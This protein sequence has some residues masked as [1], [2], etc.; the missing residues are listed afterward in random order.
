[1]KI[2]RNNSLNRKI[3]LTIVAFVSICIVVAALMLTNN[4]KES[5]IK[6]T[7]RDEQARLEQVTQA[8]DKTNE[9]C[10]LASEII[11]QSVKINQYMELLCNGK[12]MEIMEKLDF[13]QKELISIENMTNSN[14]Y[15]YQVRIYVNSEKASEKAP[16]IYR[17]Q[18]MNNM[19]WAK[20]YHDGEWKLDY[21]DT[22]FPEYIATGPKHLAGLISVVTQAGGQEMYTIECITYMTNLFPDLYEDSDTSWSAFFGDDG[23]LYYK[24]SNSNTWNQAIE[25][26]QEKTGSD[27]NVI[28]TEIDGKHVILAYQ[29]VPLLGGTYVHLVSME[30]AF[31]EFYR[32]LIPYGIILIL[33]L[34]AFVIFS[35][36]AVRVIIQ[37]FYR[38]YDVM[39]RIQ[40]G[41]LDLTL[42]EEGNDETTKLS[43]E[44]NRM[45]A[46]IQE[47]NQDNLDR[48]LLAKNAQIKSL[49]NQINAHF[50]YNVLES[51]KMMA[52]IEEKYDISD[53]ITSLGKMLR[54]S[55]KWMT[56]TVTVEEEITY[57]SNYL[58]LLN[59]RFDYEIYLSLNIPEEIS[60]MQIPKM[61]LQPLVENAVY[62][63]IE[64]MAEDTNIYIKGILVDEENCT[65]EV[66][67][68][69]RGMDEKALEELRSKIYSQ[70][71]STEESGHG[72][73][74]KNVQDR[75]Q[76]YF[77]EQYGIEIFSKEGC[78]TKVLI[79]LPRKEVR[80]EHSVDRGR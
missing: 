21:T 1:M 72:I 8:I 33:I 53:A 7:I 50:M 25:E 60:H 39:T 63:G 6:S 77:G 40:G 22:V 71:R 37:R 24:A 18:R 75:V 79:H 15:L 59:L 74:L 31:S 36:V 30:E 41:E 3:V 19:S 9:V 14:P 35:I 11:K 23:N 17:Y 64:E 55:M 65:I 76:L 70:T 49:Q 44:I 62:H 48:Q 45:L 78:Y 34:M 16:S 38:M 28:Y 69:G 26:I 32:S 54:Y 68:A 73:G 43:S 66:S 52:E 56:G 2:R 58:K 61:L 51:I 42:P 67:D 13:Y 4:M 29:Y 20:E 47:L 12:D 80:Y 57:I 46:R 10:N 27:T 5:M